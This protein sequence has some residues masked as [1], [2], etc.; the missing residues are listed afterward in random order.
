MNLP[1]LWSLFLIHINLKL[2]KQKIESSF[3]FIDTEFIFKEN[4]SSSWLHL[5]IILTHCPI[6]ILRVLVTPL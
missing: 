6:E 3:I 2:L 5:M 4:I 1:T